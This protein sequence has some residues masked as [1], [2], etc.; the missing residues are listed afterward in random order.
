MVSVATGPAQASRQCR[1]WSGC[2]RKSTLASPVMIIL[3]PCR[4]YHYVLRRIANASNIRS[5]SLPRG[6]AGVVEALPVQP[7]VG[8]PALVP[9][10]E[11]PGRLPPAPPGGQQLPGEHRVDR[12]KPPPRVHQLD[13]PDQHI[14]R[15]SGG[16]VRDELLVL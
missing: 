9:V 14:V 16:E 4:S 2:T 1:Y 11:Q 12:R 10:G 6:S 5:M 13:L 15:G 7:R 8:R 3:P